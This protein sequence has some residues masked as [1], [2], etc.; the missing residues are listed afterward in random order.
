METLNEET[1]AEERALVTREIAAG[2][3]RAAGT[4]RQLLS[5]AKRNVEELG[6]CDP[7][8]VVGRI[9]REARRLLPAHIK[10]KATCSEPPRVAISETVFEQLILNLIQNARDALHADGG[11]ISVTASLEASTDGLLLEV[12]DDG[13]GMSAE[14]AERV[15]EPFFTTRGDRGTGLGLATVWGIV[16]RHGG[17]VTLDTCPGKGTTV[18]LHLPALT[19]EAESQQRPRTESPPSTASQSRILVLEDEAPVRAA[20]C[21][22]LR[23]VGFV[24]EEAETVAEARKVSR[25]KSFALLI[26]DGVVPDGGVGRFIHEF[27]AQQQNAPV[28]LCSGY[29]EEDLAL[30]GIA[31]GEC[32]FLAKPFSVVEL[33]NLVRELLPQVELAP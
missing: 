25:G 31:S 23:H 6:D 1:D 15:F 16:H 11:T 2:V 27:R 19:E 26:S 30:E 7:H 9:A 32:A 33:T 10:L 18:G 21:R 28:I 13:P 17:E 3:E 4:A 8:A 29:L 24:V 14:V 22:V 5:F 12:E 20:L